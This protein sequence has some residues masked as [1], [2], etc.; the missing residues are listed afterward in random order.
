M[1]DVV[2]KDKFKKWPTL[3]CLQEISLDPKTQEIASEGV[4]R[5]F[6]QVLNIRELLVAVTI[7]DKTEF[8]SK[9]VR[10]NKDQNY[11]LIKMLIHHKTITTVNIYIANNKAPKY[12]KN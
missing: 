12:K 10:R 2:W 4:E 1:K 3:C 8:K 6:M 7:S 9:T 5:Y 11:I